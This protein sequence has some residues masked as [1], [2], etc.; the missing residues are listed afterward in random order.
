MTSRFRRELERID[1]SHGTAGAAKYVQ[2]AEF[3]DGL[4]WSP[5]AGALG[6]ELVRAA[7]GRARATCVLDYLWSDS[8]LELETDSRICEVVRRSMV[9]GAGSPGGASTRRAASTGWDITR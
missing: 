4:V 8:P 9:T 1:G 2:E 6:A 5:R 3:V 7:D